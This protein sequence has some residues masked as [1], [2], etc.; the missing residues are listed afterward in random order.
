[1]KRSAALIFNLLLTITICHGQDSMTDLARHFL[2]CLQGNFADYTKSGKMKWNEIE[3]K[4]TVVWQA[5]ADANRAFE[6][7]KLPALRPLTNT[8]TL[9]WA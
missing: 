9:R 6:E 2:S 5:W 1:M 7:D 4:R 8:D 3:A